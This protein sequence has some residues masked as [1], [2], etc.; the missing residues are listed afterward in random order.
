VDIFRSHPVSDAVPIARGTHV[1]GDHEQTNVKNIDLRLTSVAF[2]TSSINHF[3]I[4]KVPGVQDMVLA[5]IAKTCPL[6]GP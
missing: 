6:R 3:N 4:E 5:E 1:I 2:D